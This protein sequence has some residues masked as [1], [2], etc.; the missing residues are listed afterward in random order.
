MLED[1]ET[2]TGGIKRG[3]Y[4]QEELP[5]EGTSWTE[6]PWGRDWGVYYLYQEV[7]VLVSLFSFLFFYFLMQP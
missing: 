4:F 2:K 7:G 1:E 3:S 5:A 6:F